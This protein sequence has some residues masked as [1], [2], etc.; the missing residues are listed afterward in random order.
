MS[1]PTAN[2][3]PVSFCKD[4]QHPTVLPLW[5][6]VRASLP[7]GEA[8]DSQ[9]TWAMGLLLHII[10]QLDFRQAGRAGETF[11]GS[12]LNNSYSCAKLTSQRLIFQY[13]NKR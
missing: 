4:R 11:H 9:R 5:E 12:L 6:M 7:L 10:F 8:K 13:Q 3:V 1:A 2:T